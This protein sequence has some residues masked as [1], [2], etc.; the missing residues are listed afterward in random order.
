MI[1]IL[2]ISCSPAFCYCGAGRCYYIVF[3]TSGIR[4]V[5]F[6]TKCVMTSDGPF[7]MYKHDRCYCN[8]QLAAALQLQNEQAAWPYCKIL[9]VFGYRHQLLENSTVVLLSTTRTSKLVLVLHALHVLHSSSA[10][11]A[12]VLH[13]QTPLPSNSVRTPGERKVGKYI[14]HTTGTSWNAGSCTNV[15]SRQIINMQSPW[16]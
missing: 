16:K 12:P 4:E 8:W 13:V 10:E 2:Y 7:G 3:S 14:S 5:K 15:L 9:T 1:R 11:S 6:A